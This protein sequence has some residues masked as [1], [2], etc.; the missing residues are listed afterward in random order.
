MIRIF[1]V[2][3]NDLV[4][5]GLRSVLRNDASLTVTGEARDMA[6]ALASIDPKSVDIV[7]IDMNLPDGT[8]IEFCRRLQMH[9][10][11]IRCVMFTATA[12]AEL[13]TRAALSGAAGYL[14][15]NLPGEIIIRAIRTVFAGRL[16]FDHR[17]TETLIRHIRQEKRVENAL[18]ELTS[19]ELK[20]FHLVSDGLTN[21]Q[22]SQRIDV[23]EKT[24]RN[25]LTTLYAKLGVEN[26]SQLVALSL[27]LREGLLHTS[28]ATATPKIAV[29]C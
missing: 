22:I 25:N 13:M 21:Q 23:A 26:R 29:E 10:P 2:D 7:L 1:L 17:V 28:P 12:D 9:S 18:R 8:G 6:S 19:R 15:S 4:R 14:T 24:V 16:A 20:L 3:D 27:E 11:G 5:F